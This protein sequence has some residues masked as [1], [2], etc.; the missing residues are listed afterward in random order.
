MNSVLKKV[1]VAILITAMLIAPS[2]TMV[3]AQIGNEESSG[4]VIVVFPPGT[5]TTTYAYSS[6]TSEPITYY[7][8]S[9]SPPDGDSPSAPPA[10][11]LPAPARPRES[12]DGGAGGRHAQ[13]AARHLRYVQTSETL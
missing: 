7:Y 13:T 10:G 9:S 6:Y 12:Q 3:K 5:A 4:P 11:F 2:M 8:V 1:F